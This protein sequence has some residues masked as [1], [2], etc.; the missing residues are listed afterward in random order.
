MHPPQGHGA[1]QY[2][3]TFLDG[4]V[5]ETVVPSSWVLM[6]SRQP[7]PDRAEVGWPAAVPHWRWSLRAGT[8]LALCP[9]TRHPAWLKSSDGV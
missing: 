6:T 4:Q 9:L 3:H 7:S 5:R 8:G 1:C 2:P